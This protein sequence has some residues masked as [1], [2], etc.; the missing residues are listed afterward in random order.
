V[1]LHPNQKRVTRYNGQRKQ[2]Q[3]YSTVELSKFIEHGILSRLTE[4]RR[5]DT[6]DVP[7]TATIFELYTNIASMPYGEQITT[8]FFGKILSDLRKTGLI[9]EIDGGKS[10]RLSEA[11]WKKQQEYDKQRILF[12]SLVA[13]FEGVSRLELRNL[14]FKNNI[15]LKRGSAHDEISVPDRYLLQ[16]ISFCNSLLEEVS[17]TVKS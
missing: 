4:L 15:P 5:R 7:Q 13:K 6:T 11:M 10:F 1:S 16:A 3:T 2:M 12:E 17:F 8:G 14:L 9:A